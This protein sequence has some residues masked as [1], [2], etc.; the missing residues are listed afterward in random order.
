MAELKKLGLSRRIQTTERQNANASQLHRRKDESLWERGLN[1]N[2]SVS[3]NGALA[4]SRSK[5]ITRH[6]ATVAAATVSSHP[7]Q[8][9]GARHPGRTRHAG[10]CGLRAPDRLPSCSC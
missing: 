3:L 5:P 10:A 8:H 2:K 1:K 4:D 6:S 9:A 7:P